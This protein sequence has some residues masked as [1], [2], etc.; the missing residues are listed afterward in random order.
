MFVIPEQIITQVIE[1]KLNDLRNNPSELDEIFSGLDD[2]TK[3]E[4]KAYVLNNSIRVVRGFP[5]EPS[6]LPSYVIVLGSERE[7]IEALGSYIGDY[8]ELN[9]E[10]YGTLCVAQYRIEAWSNNGDLTVLLYQLLK[11]I[12]LSSRDSLENAG[13]TR[14]SIS[15]TDFEPVPLQYPELIYRRA[16]I[17]EVTYEVR[18]NA[19]YTR[20]ERI[21]DESNGGDLNGS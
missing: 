7:E 6:A 16:L 1:N 20:I 19:P 2:S 13:L 14:Q 4:I 18:W 9:E 12:I 21:I 10:M 17:L 15:G 11:W 3:N 5:R 8:E